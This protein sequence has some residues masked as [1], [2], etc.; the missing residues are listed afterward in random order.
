[1]MHTYCVSKLLAD[2]KPEFFSDQVILSVSF[3]I[4]V[5]GNF[6]ISV[7]FSF[8]FGVGVGAGSLLPLLFQPGKLFQLAGGQTNNHCSQVKTST[9]PTAQAWG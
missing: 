6:G 5:L 2:H 4:F 1:M 8:V 9:L 7:S 3:F